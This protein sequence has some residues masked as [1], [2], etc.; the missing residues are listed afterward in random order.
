MSERLSPLDAMF[1]YIE[2]PHV[3]MAT[4]GLSIYDPSTKPSG[5]LTRDELKHLVA[6]R[7]HLAPRFR[8]R[9]KFV[10]LGLGRPVW[11]DDEQFDL[12][13]HVREVALPAPGGRRELEDLVQRIQSVPLDRDRALWESYLVQG[14]SGG[15]VAILTRT[16]HSLVDGVGS[17]DLVTNM[18]NLTPV[19]PNE[20]PRRWRPASAPSAARLAVEAAWEQATSPVAGVWRLGRALRG[21]P[22]RVSETV[23]DTLE[24]IATYLRDNPAHPM[25]PFNRP[26]GLGRRFS[27]CEVPLDDAKRIKSALGGSVNDVI[28]ATL[29]GGLRQFLRARHFDVHGLELRAMIPVNVRETGVRGEGN[30]VSAFFVDLPAGEASAKTR[31]RLVSART[32]RLKESHEVLAGEAFLGASAY[33]APPIGAAAGHLLASQDFA[34]LV[35]SNIPGPS[36]DLYLCG[37]RHLATYPVM[38][39]PEHVGL[40]VAIVTLG[41]VMGFGFTGDRESLPDIDALADDVREAFDSLRHAAHLESRTGAGALVS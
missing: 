9:V 32:R 39:I 28:L 4:G 17:V 31:L 7:L 19:V 8:K 12:D 29:T 5:T 16:H 41:G 18:Y 24:G 37:A 26:V 34:H 33:L 23:A 40:S 15:R 22:R 38:P 6:C 11:V 14:L 36:L 27:F 10:P 3:H 20:H 21:S 1:L 2:R 35:V 25:G 30:F 13:Y